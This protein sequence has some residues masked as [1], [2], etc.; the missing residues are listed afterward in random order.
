[1]K[2]QTLKLFIAGM[3]ITGSIELLQSQPLLSVP[4][5]SNQPNTAD[6]N[7]ILPYKGSWTGKLQY[8][9]FQGQM[10]LY[11]DPSGDLYGSFESNTGSKFAQISG[12]HR[13]NAFHMVFTPPPGSS[14]YGKD[15]EP[16]TFDAS[17]K[18]VSLNR[19]V[20]SVPGHTGHPQS[21][22]FDRKVESRA[23]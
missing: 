1:M 8:V 5:Q 6:K 18:L 22:I 2:M 11:I 17:A 21:Y 9:G 19:F 12:D 23:R 13:G 4:S 16:Y 20:I 3:L 7:F 14:F 10:L 15:A